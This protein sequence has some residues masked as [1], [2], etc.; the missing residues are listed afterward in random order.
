MNDEDQPS[1]TTGYSPFGF[2]S[3]VQLRRCFS[4]GMDNRERFVFVSPLLKPQ[5]ISKLVAN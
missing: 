3:N 5:I 4:N 2:A 1:P